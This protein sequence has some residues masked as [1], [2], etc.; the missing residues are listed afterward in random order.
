MRCP[1]CGKEV[2][3]GGGRVPRLSSPLAVRRRRRDDAW[4]SRG[5]RRPD[6][7]WPARRRR[8]DDAWRSR[9]RRPD[10]A[11]PAR[12]RRPD[13]AW[14]PPAD[15]GR[16]MLG[17]PADDG[18]TMLGAPADDGRTMLGPPDDGARLPATGHL[19]LPRTKPGQCSARRHW[20]THRRSRV[21]TGQ[22]ARMPRLTAAAAGRCHGRWIPQVPSASASSSVRATSS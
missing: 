19:P 21:G 5:R 3:D 14:R 10:R 1:S 20:V 13:D 16:T 12:R 15:E 8:P 11:W 17:A 2:P 18:R 9:R 6:R 4:R 22:S 7:A